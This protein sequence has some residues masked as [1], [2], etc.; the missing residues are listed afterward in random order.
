MYNE[1]K[2]KHTERFLSMLSMHEDGI[3]GSYVGIWEFQL[4]RST[5][6]RGAFTT[7]Q[8]GE[9]RKR[10]GKHSFPA[11]AGPLR[12]VTRVGA[13]VKNHSFS[14]FV[15]FFPFLEV[16]CHPLSGKNILIAA[17]VLIC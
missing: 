4:S 9:L 12:L 15:R 6:A 10:S 13:Q 17:W 2:E 14:F 1:V 16:R 7:Q 3:Y 11:P 5:T 8:A